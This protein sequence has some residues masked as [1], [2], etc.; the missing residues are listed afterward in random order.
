LAREA[1]LQVVGE[2][3]DLMTL[4]HGITRY[5]IT[6]ACY[7]ADHAGGEFRSDFYAAGEWVAPGE[8]AAYPVSAPQRRL[9]KAVSAAQQGRLF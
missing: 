3:R 7:E 4:T 8:L 6:L 9:A 5:R 1:G 2:P